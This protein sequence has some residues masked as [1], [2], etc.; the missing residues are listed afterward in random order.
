MKSG[1]VYLVGAGPG[2][3]GLITIRGLECLRCADVVV[4]DRLVPRAL[5]KE[6]KPQAKL[7][8]VGKEAS[9]HAFPQEKINELLAKEARAGQVVCRLKGGDPFI[10]GRGGEEA[11]YLAERGIPFEVVP[12]ITSAIAAPAFAGIP[13]THRQYASSVAFITG[14]E[15]VEK[16]SSSLNWQALAKGPDTLVFLMGMANLSEITS[17]L[18]ENGK[19]ADTPAALIRW[20]ATPSQQTV[21]G[22][23]SDIAEK[24]QAAALRP[25]AVIVIGEVVRLREK[26]AWYERKPL[27]GKTILISRARE[28]A[29][30]LT[31]RLSSLGAEVI[32]FPVIKIVPLPA[33][34]EFLSHLPQYDWVIFT[35]ANGVKFFLEHLRE[36]G[37]DLR[38]L[39]KAKIA[40]IGPATT[41][42]LESLGLKVDFQPAQFL[43]ERVLEEFPENPAGLRLLLPR[44]REA[45]E[46]LPEGLRE[47]GAKVE[48][49]PVYETVPDHP[50]AENLRARLS[51]GEIDLIC[52][53]SSSTVRNFLTAMGDAN[54]LASVT[55]A[56]IGP[57]T[58]QTA[59]EL[60]LTVRI[61]AKEHTIPGLVEA[62][63]Q[64]S[65][66]HRKSQ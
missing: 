1:I 7:V 26:L 12:G 14:Q 25:P 53:T 21:V 38:A 13:L 50:E 59:E 36:A 18:V 46:V 43:A 54:L 23:L 48:V 57:V 22:T 49:Y 45:R 44:A 51:A 65:I 40:S 11:L 62:I 66:S 35:S 28:Q 5:L 9:R 16:L 55:I 39:G 20:G 41:A 52:F 32:E 8:Y 10:F 17:R 24:A 30:E 2:D 61:T 37:R 19:P 31:S 47:R 15:D 27:F 58:T 6:A 34:R 33:D 3:P 4:Y 42:A 56:S 29:S 60:G 64:Y 63:K